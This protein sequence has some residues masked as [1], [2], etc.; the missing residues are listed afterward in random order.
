[1]SKI[2]V[3]DNEFNKTDTLS[4]PESYKDISPHNFY[5]Y[6][7]AYLSNLRCAN[8]H[9]KTRAEVRGGGKKPWQQKGRGGARAG[10]IRSPIFVGGGVA[11]GPRNNRNYFQKINKKQKKLA[12]KY[13]LYEKGSHEKLFAVDRVLVESRKT[14]D[15]AKIV[16]KIGA[17]DVLFVVKSIEEGTYLAFRNLPN[18]YLIEENELNAYIL[19]S[20]RA[21]VME[22]K[23]L[24][25]LVKE[26]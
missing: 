16:E 17:R 14:K 7:K 4:L 21:V 6:V 19:A 26:G 20:Y 1:M 24:E 11:F 2:I 22:K 15:A 12:F 5:L 18:T 25:N 3:L 10:S 8:A 13:A 23:V 9:A